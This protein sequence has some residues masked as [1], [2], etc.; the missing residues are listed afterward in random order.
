MDAR[1][2]LP[3]IRR[4]DET[5]PEFIFSPDTSPDVQ[6]QLRAVADDLLNSAP[7]ERRFQRE[8]KVATILGAIAIAGWFCIVA[9]WGTVLMTFGI[10]GAVV[11][12]GAV[13]SG[14]SVWKLTKRREQLHAYRQALINPFKD[15]DEPGQYKLRVVI[16]AIDRV[17]VSRAAREGR[18]PGWSELVGHQL[19]QITC[20]LKAL[21]EARAMLGPHA[22]ALPTQ[23]AAVLEADQAIARTVDQLVHYAGSVA[24]VD[25]SLAVLDTVIQRDAIDDRLREALAAT[26][27]NYLGATLTDGARQAQAEVDAA[28]RAVRALSEQLGH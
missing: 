22:A 14:T 10:A 12:L 21:S 13:V 9:G 20:G 19:W 26:S 25:H 15:L 7:L 2:P 5:L 23:A 17:A 1:A 4:P 6:A 8:R 3:W 27:G 28:L 11:T 16:Q 18:L 24:R